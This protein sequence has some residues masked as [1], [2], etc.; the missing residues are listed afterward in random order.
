[1]IRKYN[2]CPRCGGNLLPEQDE[3]IR[4]LYCLQCGYRTE[5]EREHRTNRHNTK[6]RR[7]TLRSKIY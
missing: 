3:N 5:L 1:M 2:N 6:G 4:Y 7:E